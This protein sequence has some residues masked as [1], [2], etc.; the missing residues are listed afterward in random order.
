MLPDISTLLSTSELVR[1]C[2]C[3]LLK[4]DDD[5]SLAWEQLL[6]SHLTSIKDFECRFSHTIHDY[7]F[8]PGM[9]ILVL[10]KKIE[11]TSNAKCKPRYFGPM[12]VISHST[13]GS[14]CLAE[15]DGSVLKL[16][17]T[18]FCLIPY[19]PRS[20]NSLNVTQYINVE[21]L[22]STTIDKD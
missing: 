18:A 8:K 1:L 10:N 14:Y 22:A 9:L 5:L 16:K 19:H 21:N 4:R 7:D 11:A 6:K 2:T 3:Q 13:G 12:V 20:P 17:F 15:I